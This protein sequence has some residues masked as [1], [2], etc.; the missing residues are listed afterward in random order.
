MNPDCTSVEGQITEQEGV[1]TTGQCVGEKN[2]SKSQLLL[3][4]C[5][6]RHK[7]LKGGRKRG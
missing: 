1:T 4:D 5:T 6:I 2:I 7:T 3:S